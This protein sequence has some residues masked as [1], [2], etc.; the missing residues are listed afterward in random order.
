MTFTSDFLSYQKSRSTIWELERLV[1]LRSQF[2]SASIDVSGIGAAILKKI[3]I[4]KSIHGVFTKV[5]CLHDIER[6]GKIRMKIREDTMSMQDGVDE[7]YTK[8]ESHLQGG[9][10][11]DETMRVKLGALIRLSEDEPESERVDLLERLA[12]LARKLSDSGIYSAIADKIRTLTQS[13]FSTPG[14][15]AI[16]L[17]SNITGLKAISPLYVLKACRPMTPTVL[18][19]CHLMIV[20]RYVRLLHAFP[21][22]QAVLIHAT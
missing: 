12:E 11:L 13:M 6:L 15:S 17:F 18:S 5:D 14:V 21:K 3:E 1:A 16:I 7:N 4:L 19:Y 9:G 10:V 20:D 8:L 2:L 22:N